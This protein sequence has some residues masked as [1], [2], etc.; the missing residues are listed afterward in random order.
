MQKG[1]TGHREEHQNLRY[2]NLGKKFFLFTDIK[3]SEYLAKFHQEN[4]RS[5][6]LALKPQEYQFEIKHIPGEKNAADGLSRCVASIQI[7][8]VPKQ[9]DSKMKRE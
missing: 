9:I 5:T 1:I 6:R 3:A 4:S 7:H 2:Y 8:N